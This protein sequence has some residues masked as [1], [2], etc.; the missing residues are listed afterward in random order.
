MS[1]PALGAAGDLD[2]SFGAVGRAGPILNGPAWSLQPLDDGTLL[3]AG[4]TSY[5][6]YHYDTQ[7]VIEFVSR[8]TAARRS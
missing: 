7:V 3:L 6:Y 8:V 1:P 2:P 4:G 5:H